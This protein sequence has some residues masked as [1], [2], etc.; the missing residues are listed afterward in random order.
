MINGI[1]TFIST[2][3]ASGDTNLSITSNIDSTYDVYM[4]VFTAIHPSVD[5][6]A[7]TFN[8]S[9]DG[10]SSYA[11]TKTTTF[12]KVKTANGS[13]GDLSYMPAEDLAQSTDYQIISDLILNDAEASA[14]GILY[15]FGPS[16]TTYVK[17]F[18]GRSNCFGEGDRTQ[19]MFVG[20]YFNTTSAINAVDFKISTGNFDGVIQMYGIG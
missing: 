6:P 9:T 4:F 8:G 11:V 16:S 17:N 2:H 18:N 15:L 7:F 10:G 5:R 12:F 13:S 20:G 1:P 3:P 14:A 19:D